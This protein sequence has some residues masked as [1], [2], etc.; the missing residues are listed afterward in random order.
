MFKAGRLAEYNYDDK[1]YL[2][3][4]IRNDYGT[5]EID[6]IIYEIDNN[7]RIIGVSDA[8]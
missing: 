1:T 7:G 8:E 4:G 6:G 5:Q 3:N 2:S